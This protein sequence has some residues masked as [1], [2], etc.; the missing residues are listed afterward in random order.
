MPAEQRALTSGA[1][2]MMARRGECDDPDNTRE[3]PE[4]SEEALRQGE[5]GTGHKVSSRG[6][7]RFPDTVV[8]GELGVIRQSR[9]HLGPPPC[10]LR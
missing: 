7:K 5:G 10:A 6:T 3:A 8:F 1:L 4:P 2:L 9:V